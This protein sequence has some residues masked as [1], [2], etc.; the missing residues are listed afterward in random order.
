[1][2]FSGNV[3]YLFF[4]FF[5]FSVLFLSLVHNVSLFLL[6]LLVTIDSYG[7]ITS[8]KVDYYCHFFKI[9]SSESQSYREG[10]TERD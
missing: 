10:E 5:F 9:Y 4:L 8:L 3:I 1:M 7:L 6:E 2:K